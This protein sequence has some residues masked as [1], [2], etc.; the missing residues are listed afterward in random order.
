M[1][2]RLLR[3]GSLMEAS[4]AM[5]EFQGMVG[6]GEMNTDLVSE[7][8]TATDLGDVVEFPAYDAMGET[9]QIE[10][11][12]KVKYPLGASNKMIWERVRQ[13]DADAFGAASPDAAP[14]ASEGEASAETP[15]AAP[16]ESAGESDFVVVDKDDVVMEQKT[17]VA[18]PSDSAV[19]META[20]H[21]LA[22]ADYE[23]D[24]AAV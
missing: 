14:A 9:I 20:E 17:E 10:D 13:H 11:G 15:A 1:H 3:E 8:P 12:I 5:L 23:A 7:E 19:P 24:D 6:R 2:Y 4:R 21:V 18:A 16:E 22:D